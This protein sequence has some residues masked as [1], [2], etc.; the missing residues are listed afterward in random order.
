MQNYTYKNK[1]IIAFFA[2]FVLC[3]L[4]IMFVL[5]ESAQRSVSEMLLTATDTEMR[6]MIGYVPDWTKENHHDV[7]NNIINR[8]TGRNGFMTGSVY[9]TP[10]LIALPFAFILFKFTIS[11]LVKYALSNRDDA[12]KTKLP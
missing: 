4:V 11:P 6:R 5:R 2:L 7:V 1:I 9:F 12:E 8:G 3:Y 10:L